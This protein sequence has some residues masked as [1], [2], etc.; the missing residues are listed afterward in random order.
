MQG[1]LVLYLMGQLKLVI[2]ENT[3]CFLFDENGTVCKMKELSCC[4]NSEAGVPSCTPFKTILPNACDG[5][6]EKSQKSCCRQC[7]CKYHNCLPT[8]PLECR[9]S[10]IGDAL[11][12]FQQSLTQSF[13]GLLATSII[14]YL[15]IAGIVLLV[16][17]IGVIFHLYFK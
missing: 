1:L 9:Q 14:K 4:Q 2:S 17:V 13:L 5:Y 8:Q 6:D 16:I 12:Y 11:S 10:T 15:F 7:D 3:G